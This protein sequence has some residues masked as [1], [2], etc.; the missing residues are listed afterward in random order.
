MPY[1]ISSSR[2]AFLLVD[3]TPLLVLVLSVEANRWFQ[4]E[5]LEIVRTKKQRGGP[6]ALTWEDYKHMDFTQCVSS[7]AMHPFLDR[8][9]DR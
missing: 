1:L 6:P 4:E 2:L 3:G 5:H 7:S 9:I 8:S